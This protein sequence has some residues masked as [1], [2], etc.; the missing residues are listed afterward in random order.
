MRVCGGGAHND[1]T[2]PADNA[3]LPWADRLRSFEESGDLEG[4]RLMLAKRIDEYVEHAERR[5]LVQ[6]LGRERAL[7]DAP[8]ARR[9]FGT[10]TAE[11]LAKLPAGVDDPKRLA[12]N[13]A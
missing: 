1:G 13:H 7:A 11:H 3:P 10:E 4:T 9:K 6:G 12:E 5:G 8:Q 2:Q